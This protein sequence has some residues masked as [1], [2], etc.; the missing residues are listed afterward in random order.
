MTKLQ[1][2][3]GAALNVDGGQSCLGLR[4]A[5]IRFSALDFV[6]G[7]CYNSWRYEGVAY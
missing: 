3:E 6:A 2:E 7:L 4:G 1:I 5:L